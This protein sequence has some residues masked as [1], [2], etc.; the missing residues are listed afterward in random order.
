MMHHVRKGDL[1]QYEERERLGRIGQE[2]EVDIAPAHT[3]QLG[4]LIMAV[5]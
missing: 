5:A 2:R 1:W 4:G 3:L